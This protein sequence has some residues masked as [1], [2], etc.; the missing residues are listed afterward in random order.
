MA[1]GLAQT[2]KMLLLLLFVVTVFQE[3]RTRPSSSAR[4]RRDS[5]D[6]D[7]IDDIVR[8]LTAQT[9]RPLSDDANEAM[10]LLSILISLQRHRKQTDDVINRS[11]SDSQSDVT[12]RK[13]QR[14]CFWSV[15]TCY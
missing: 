1:T 8:D 5:D 15:V 7:G 4:V 2:A 11:R 3:A 14:Q 6:D 13:R 9:Q 12:L 10:T